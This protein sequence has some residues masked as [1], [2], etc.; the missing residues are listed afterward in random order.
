MSARQAQIPLDASLGL[1]TQRLGPLPLINHFLAR[2]G[3]E[4]H[5]D[6]W[7]PTKDRRIRL[8]YAKGLGVLLRSI[9]VEREPIY[10]QKETVNTFAKEAF[11]LDAKTVRHVGDDAIGRAL[12]RLFDADRA[13]LL[14]EVVV[15]ATKEFE[16]T[17]DELHNDSTSIRFCGQYR[18]AKGRRM[19]GRRAPYITY[20]HS[21]DH[22][23]DLKQL[24][25]ILTTTAEG[26]VPVQFRCEA[27]NCSDSRTHQETWDTLCLATGRVD[28]LYVADSKLCSREAMDHIDRRGGRFVTVIPRA[29]G[30]DSEFREWIQSHEPDW[31]LVWDRP[32]P[33]RKGGPRDRWSVFR[34]PLPSRESWPVIWVHSALLALR[35]EQTRREHIARATQELSDLNDKLQGPRARRRSRKDLQEQVGRSRPAPIV[36]PAPHGV[37][38]PR[39]GARADPARSL[40]PCRPLSHRTS[41]QSADPP[42]PRRPGRAR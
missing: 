27:G 41:R 16:L 23:S 2:L 10:R 35:Q 9:L 14:T 7:V 26:G 33:R 42:G 6:R 29:R 32:N 39:A 11:G 21:T 34:Y 28:F 5:L 17:L 8:P 40:R 18:Q 38:P 4:E 1:H 22:R 3:M 31:T 19:R 20:G 15:A 36:C 24:L 30:E 13:T 25:F 12:D 37:L